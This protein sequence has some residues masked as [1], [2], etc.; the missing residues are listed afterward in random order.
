[1]LRRFSIVLVGGLFLLFLVPI[2]RVDALVIE[3]ASEKNQITITND[4]DDDLLVKGEGVVNVDAD[5]NGDLII[6]GETVNVTGDVEGNVYVL[7]NTVT[8]ENIVGKSVY[9]VS[10]TTYLNGEV[11][12]DVYLMGGSIHLSGPVKE[13]VIIAGGDV[14]VQGSVGDDIRAFAGSIRVN[15]TVGGDIVSA[16]GNTVIDGIVE[17]SVIS[18]GATDL[19]SSLVGGDFIVYTDK[20]DVVKYSESTIQGDR[21]IKGY[22]QFGEFFTKNNTSIASTLIQNIWAKTFWSMFQCIGIVILGYLLFKFAPVR[23]ES[24]IA[25]MND[26]QEV[27][28]SFITGFIAFP[29]GVFIALFLAFSVFGWPVLMVIMLLALLATS[30]VTPIAGIVLG[31]KI[32]PLLGSKR[33]YVVALTLGVMII[34]ILK[35]IPVVGWFF[36]QIV[37]FIVIG[38]MLRMQWS[39]YKMA[40][41]MTVKISK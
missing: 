30:V 35:T 20:N 31:R 36:Y 38:A 8:L 34:Q 14:Y 22:E 11:Y 28:K 7:G 3:N 39:K 23:L 1:M 6:L 2:N 16:S 13:D 25:K 33:K 15:S 37:V 4:V 18:G 9:I 21:S 26:T 27:L 40:Q 41:N 29:I 5:V 19:R 32:L 12:R 10:G 24:T 17:G